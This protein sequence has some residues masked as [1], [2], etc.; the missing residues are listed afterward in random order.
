MAEYIKGKT[1]GPDDLRIAIRDSKYSTVINPFSI[2]Y[3]IWYSSPYHD[4]EMSPPYNPVKIADGIFFAPYTIPL[5][6][7]TGPWL[8]RWNIVET[9]G[10]PITEV[11]QE[12]TVT[13]K[14][15]VVVPAYP[16]AETIRNL[17]AN[18]LRIMLRDNNPDRNY[19]FRP[20]NT[21]A[22]L[23][24]QTEVFGYIWESYELEEYLIMSLDDLNSSPPY[25]TDDFM[26]LPERWRTALLFRAA[27]IACRAV[28]MN[29][30]ADEFAYSIGGVSLDIDKSSKYQSM[31]DGYDQQYETA[32]QLLKSSIKITKGLSQNRYGIGISSALGPMTAPGSMSRRNF[33]GR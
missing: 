12:F 22:M 8:V 17:M 27:A 15:T 2:T 10:S 16:T 33:V 6:A 11:V 29:W 9:V 30:V 14:S 4:V 1:L 19:R 23:Q 32:R 26:S 25:R 21:D 20:P 5:D 31:A 24:A 28:S 3:S 7:E 18:R 13:E